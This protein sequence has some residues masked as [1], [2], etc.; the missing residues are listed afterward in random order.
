[1]QNYVLL[2]LA[3][4]PIEVPVQLKLEGLEDVQ[5]KTE[6]MQLELFLPEDKSDLANRVWERLKNHPLSGSFFDLKGLLGLD[7]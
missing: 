7:S 1:M 4:G 3:C 6:N 2:R 5:P